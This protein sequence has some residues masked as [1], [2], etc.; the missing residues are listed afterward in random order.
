MNELNKLAG[1]VRYALNRSPNGTTLEARWISTR[2]LDGNQPSTGL[3]TRV[4]SEGSSRQ[5]A[6]FGGIWEVVYYGLDGSVQVTPFLLVLEKVGEMS[7]CFSRL[8]LDL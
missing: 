8:G 5:E 6:T 4:G 1:L 7:S 2:I 3:A